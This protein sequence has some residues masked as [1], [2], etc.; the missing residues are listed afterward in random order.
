MIDHSKFYDDSD[1]P[2]QARKQLLWSRIHGTISTRRNTSIIR[3]HRR[4]FVWGLAASILFM[5]ATVGAYASWKFLDERNQPR[6]LKLDRAYQSAIREFECVAFSETQA[7]GVKRQT[8]ERAIRSEQLSQLDAAITRLRNETSGRD[9][10]PLVQSR[11]RSLYSLKLQ[12]LQQMIEQ[13]DLE[14]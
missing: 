10:S 2:D 9:L 4:S 6:P 13:G 3:F 8:D 5:L 11:L 12:I 14:L 1:T 7:G